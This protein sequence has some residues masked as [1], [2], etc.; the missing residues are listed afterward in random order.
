MYDSIKS[1]YAYDEYERGLCYG[2]HWDIHTFGKQSLSNTNACSN[3]PVA[4]GIIIQLP[5]HHGLFLNQPSFSKKLY[6]Y[7][8]ALVAKYMAIVNRS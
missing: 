8:A 6:A 2:S 3:C 5:H 4:N 1:P 7:S